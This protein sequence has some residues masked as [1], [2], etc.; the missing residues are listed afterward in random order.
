LLLARQACRVDSIGGAK[1]LTARLLRDGR[2][3]G[4]PE[5][6]PISADDAIPLFHWAGVEPAAQAE[7]P[8]P[9]PRRRWPFRS[10]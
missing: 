2:D 8:V 3:S 9:S 6:P 4:E 10:A 5:V 1:I 7:D